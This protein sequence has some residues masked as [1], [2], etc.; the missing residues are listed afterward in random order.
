MAKRKRRSNAPVAAAAEVR[1]LRNGRWQ[2]TATGKF[3]P[4]VNGRP[5]PPGWKRDKRGA[6]YNVAAKRKQAIANFGTTRTRGKPPAQ[7]ANLA[8]RAG[9]ALWKGPPRPLWPTVYMTLA[10]ID[11]IADD[12]EKSRALTSWCNS[13]AVP[14]TK[15]PPKERARHVV[16][17]HWHVT[18][19][20]H[21]TAWMTVTLSYFAKQK[22]WVVD[23]ST[24]I[25][26]EP[27]EAAALGAEN[28]EKPPSDLEKLEREQK[29][30]SVDRVSV[31]VPIRPVK[32]Q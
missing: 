19:A 10:E 26:D 11:R 22:V 32:R 4:Q 13:H 20:R 9:I 24:P 23:S 12:P 3:A 18:V 25:S 29:D 31:H 21:G 8:I 2:Y 1:Q 16:M 17:N 5:L 27:A 6:A 28:R 15:Y 7:T 14:A 30:E